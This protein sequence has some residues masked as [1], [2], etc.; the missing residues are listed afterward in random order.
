MSQALPYR[1]DMQGYPGKILQ[2][3]K[4]EH[5]APN[6]V[7]ACLVPWASSPRTRSVG[8]HALERLKQRRGYAEQVRARRFN[9]V[10]CESWTSEACKNFFPVQPCHDMGTY[11]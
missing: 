5:G 8:I 2:R 11:N 6:F 9:I 1:H 3:R 4:E 10:C 7:L